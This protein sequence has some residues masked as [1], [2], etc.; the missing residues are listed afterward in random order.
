MRVPRDGPCLDL[1]CAGRVVLKAIVP[2]HRDLARTDV[3]NYVTE[4]AAVVFVP[5]GD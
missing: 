5:D 2:L 4:T 3:E 1:I